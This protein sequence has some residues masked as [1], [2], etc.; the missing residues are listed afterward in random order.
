[1]ASGTRRDIKIAAL[2]VQR[3]KLKRRKGEGEAQ[4]EERNV[5]AQIKALREMLAVDG[6]QPVKSTVDQGMLLAAMS[7]TAKPTTVKID[8]HTAMNPKTGDL[9]PI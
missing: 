4:A 6:D 3:Q 9:I 5:R 2:Q 1:M 8:D 7:L